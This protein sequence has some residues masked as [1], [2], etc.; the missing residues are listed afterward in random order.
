MMMFEPLNE[1]TYE[2]SAV[3][4][5]YLKIFPKIYDDFLLR[6]DA[7]ELTIPSNLPLTTSPGQAVTGTAGPVPVAGTTVSIGTGQVTPIYTGILPGKSGPAMLAR[8]Q[9]EKIAGGTAI[10]APIDFLQSET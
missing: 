6:S 1:E 10:T 5:T 3:N 2:I 8:R 4:I 9:A 7:L